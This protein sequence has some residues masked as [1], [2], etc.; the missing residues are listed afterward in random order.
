MCI[1]RCYDTLQSRRIAQNNTLI[2]LTNK[3]INGEILSV[4]FYLRKT[5]SI[6]L[7]FHR[8]EIMQEDVINK[9]CIIN[10]YYLFIMAEKMK[11]LQS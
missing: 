10:T 6:Q 9:Y 5:I 1:N 4:S 7:Y 11:D 3:F 2:K 8:Q